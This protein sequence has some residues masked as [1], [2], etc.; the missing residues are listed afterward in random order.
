MTHI[1]LTPENRP[2]REP[3]SVTVHR[4]ERS[5]GDHFWYVIVTGKDHAQVS[6]HFNTIGAVRNFAD[7]VHADARA[8]AADSMVARIVTEDRAQEWSDTGRR[9]VDNYEDQQRDRAEERYNA[10][11]LRSE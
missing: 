4:N 7:A 10:D 1:H 8:V 9:L 11:T 3:Y 2:D 6:F 5:T